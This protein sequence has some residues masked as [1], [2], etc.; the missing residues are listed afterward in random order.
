VP[1]ASRIQ[2]MA[3]NKDPII[4]F[5]G[6]ED[7]LEMDLKK[8]K[9][10]VERTKSELEAYRDA[11]THERQKRK[12]YDG[13]IGKGKYND[14]ALHRAKKQMDI[15]IRHFADKVKLSEEKIAH[16]QEIVDRLEVELAAQYRGLKLLE[17]HRNNGSAN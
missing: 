4:V 8:H 9:G 12:H 2:S 5:E 10:V 15:N 3:R 6:M 16:H 17:E 11:R 7:V 13:L 14:D 1:P